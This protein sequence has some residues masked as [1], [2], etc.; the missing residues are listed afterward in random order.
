MKIPD[1]FG[2][3]RTRSFCI[4]C[5]VAAA[6]LLTVPGLG[7][8]SSGSDAHTQDSAAAHGT[9]EGAATHN[10]DEGAAHGTGEAGAHGE[11]GHGGGIHWQDT[12]SYRVLNFAI[13]AI[14][15]FLLLRKPAASALNGRIKGIQ[16][17]LDDLESRKTAV[18][19]QLAEYNAKLAEL[20]KEAAQI[21]EEYTRQGQEAKTRILNE[22]RAAADKLKEQAHKNIAYE[23][24]QAKLVL[25]AD[26]VEKALAKAEAL[27]KDRISDK[28]QDRLVD[29]YL[30]KVVA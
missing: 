20:D 23:F 13:L 4:L 6:V 19:K 8:S 3:R 11:G 14:G 26:I 25:Q 16:S 12:D 7:W 24:E 21:V 18:E 28:D 29:E 15:L 30:E 5:L 2:K 9:A 10:I 17:E 1:R 22:A 27:I